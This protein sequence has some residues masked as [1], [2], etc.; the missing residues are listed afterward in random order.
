L[1]HEADYKII[2]IT[3]KLDDN[4]AQQAW[5][6]LLVTYSKEPGGLHFKS[7]YDFI[8]KTHSLKLAISKTDSCVLSVLV[9][10]KKNGL[11]IC[12]LGRKRNSI[13]NGKESLIALIKDSLKSC[14]IEASGKAEDFI[15]KH[16]EGK[17][18]QVNDSV[19]SHLLGGII[20]L[21]GDGYHY[22]RYI[23]EIRMTKEKCI[24]GTFSIVAR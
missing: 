17:L 22:T 12:A 14:W 11:K 8:Q 13:H 2:T 10:K 24:Y 20:I 4:L 23:P 16:C 7:F 19:I 9:L 21:K 3:S 1:W 15:N 6:I 5:D 18:Y